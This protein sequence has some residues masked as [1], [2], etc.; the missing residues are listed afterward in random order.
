[1][2]TANVVNLVVVA[3]YFIATAG[4]GLFMARYVKTADDFFLG[5]H[6]LNKWV[7]A[8]SIM[9]AN[10]AAIY[11]IGPAGAAAAGGGAATLLIAWVGNMIAAL[12]AT[13]IVP[14]LRRLRIMTV[15][16]I[17]ERRY[18]RAVRLLPVLFWLFYYALFSGN[19][20]FA[21]GTCLEPFVGCPAKILILIVGPLVI[22][23]CAFSGLLGQAYTAVFQSFIIILGG[24]ILLPMAVKS[25]GGIE[26][27][28]AKIDPDQFRFWKATGEAW[29]TW[30]DVFMFVLLGLPYWC[31]SQYLLQR[32]FAA[33]SVEHASRGL[34]LAALMTGFLTLCYILPSMCAP[35]LIPEGSDAAAKIA[36]RGD[37]VLP[38]LFRELFPVGLAGLIVAALISASNSTASAL[39]NS[40]AT[41]FVNDIARTRDP[42]RS[43]LLG[44]IVT[45]VAGA[46]GI[47]FAF[48]VDR[49]GGLIKANF[50]IMQF[51]E[52]PIFVIVFAALF[53]RFVNAWGAGASL[54]AGIACNGI[55]ALNKMNATERI[56]IDFVVCLVVIVVGSLLGRLLSGKPSPERQQQLDDFYNAMKGE[57][58]RWMHPRMLIG[59]LVALLGLGLFVAEA[60]FEASFPKPGNILIVFG[61]M[62]V[63]V[64]GIWLLIPAVVGREAEEERGSEE[65]ERS[66]INRL[67][68][69]GWTWLAFYSGMIVLIVVLYMIS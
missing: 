55:L 27:F 38:I 17:V 4:L 9:S 60:L 35:H 14:R 40:S 44:R 59:G 54:L 6:S 69:S 15:T 25:M 5:G 29:P 34:V 65:M 67:F 37:L 21:L 28:A 1:M 66:A 63:F 12:S 58:V 50:E 16:D 3:I 24:V 51:F 43:I 41:L 7:I 32:T 39:L 47:V 68:G 23:Y 30:K 22:L 20:M 2:D 36:E 10:V 61:S 48:N 19:A 31:T 11:L 64:F 62:M 57:P 42:K 53:W 18:N 13:I 8:G 45:V 52:P 33:R 26:A 46:I 56:F 49:L